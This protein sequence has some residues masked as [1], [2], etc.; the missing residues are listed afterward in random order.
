MELFEIVN[1]L[2]ACSV[3]A[4]VGGMTPV[5]LSHRLD[6]LAARICEEEMAELSLC[7]EFNEGT[8]APAYD[9]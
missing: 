7:A 9:A 8:N 3:D 6:K 4:A 2:R 5:E 1:E